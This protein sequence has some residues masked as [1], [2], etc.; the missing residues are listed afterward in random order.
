MEVTSS[1]NLGDAG[2]QPPHLRRQHLCGGQGVPKDMPRGQFDM[3]RQDLRKAAHS[4]L[5]TAQHSAAAAAHS[6]ILRLPGLSPPR[7]CLMHLSSHVGAVPP[8]KSLY[9]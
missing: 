9:H 5:S 8:W 1:L 7:M 2:R 3:W 6:L 4:Q